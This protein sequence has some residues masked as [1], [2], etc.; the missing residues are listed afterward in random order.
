MKL[1]RRNVW[2]SPRLQLQDSSLRSRMTSFYELSFP[3]VPLGVAD[4]VIAWSHLERFLGYATT[5]RCKQRG[6]MT[7]SGGELFGKI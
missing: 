3:L 6:E 2:N 4:Y 1:R 7:K 5:C